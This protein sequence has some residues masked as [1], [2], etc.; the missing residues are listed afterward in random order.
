MSIAA[1]MREASAQDH[2]NAESMR[3][4]QQ[5]MGGALSSNEYVA[6]LTQLAHVYRA[7][8]SKLVD[9]DTMPFSKS[10]L[11]MENILRDLEAL[12]AEGW[13]SVAILKSTTNYVERLAEFRDRH[14]IRLVAHHYTRYLGDLSGGQAIAS[15]VRRHYGLTEEQ[16]TFYRFDL[17]ED[18]VRFKEA[19]RDSLD[20][21]VLDEE[22]LDTLLAEVQVAFRLNQA[23]FLELGGLTP[24]LQH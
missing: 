5:L 14:D 10:L 8:E 11:R 22:Q 2:K 4:V 7:L 21:L 3:F 15:L 13:E 1:Q 16:T 19:Y 9:I 23:L 24:V 17:I 6:Y 18:I 12:G 20:A